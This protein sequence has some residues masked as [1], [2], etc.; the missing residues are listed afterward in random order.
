[1][2]AH[3]EIGSKKVIKLITSTIDGFYLASGRAA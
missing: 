1:M 3:G 2:R